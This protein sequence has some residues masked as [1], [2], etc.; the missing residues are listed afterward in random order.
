MCRFQEEFWLFGLLKL[1]SFLGSFFAL[2]V[3]DLQALMRAHQMKAA[4]AGRLNRIAAKPSTWYEKL[5][6]RLFGSEA[7]QRA[8]NLALLRNVAASLS[9]AALVYKYL[10]AASGPP[11]RSSKEVLSDWNTSVNAAAAESPQSLHNLNNL[12]VPAV[13]NTVAA[14]HD[15]YGN[16][17][18]K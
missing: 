6:H 10:P 17:I 3:M 9:F 2:L 1:N 5:Y 7:E 11:I 18:S 16:L 8:A 15:Y 4:A 13:S 12:N 14:Q